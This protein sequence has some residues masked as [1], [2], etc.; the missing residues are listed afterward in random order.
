[1]KKKP[2]SNLKSM[3]IAGLS[4]RLRNLLRFSFRKSNFFIGKKPV[5]E[6]ISVAVNNSSVLTHI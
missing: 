5:V 4:K 6:T 1:M 3:Q 2:V